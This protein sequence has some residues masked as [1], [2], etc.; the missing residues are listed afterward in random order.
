[1]QVNVLG[2][3]YNVVKCT[4]KTDARLEGSFGICDETTKEI[5]VD[6]LEEEARQPTAKQNMDAMRKKILRHEIIHAFLCESGL[7][8]CSEWAQNEEMVDW[9]A[10]QAPKL[11]RAWRQ[12]GALDMSVEG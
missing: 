11:V 2:T 8:E 10:K 4:A 1:M 6:T 5:L 9:F 3:P 12:A 7:A